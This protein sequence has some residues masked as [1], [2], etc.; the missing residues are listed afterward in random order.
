MKI[1]P[2]LLILVVF[3]T[4]CKQN[5]NAGSGAKNPVSTTGRQKGTV[6]PAN[7]NQDTLL[8]NKRSAVSFWLDSVQLEKRKNQYGANFETGADDYAYYSDVADSVLGTKHLPVINGDGY[9]YIKFV[10]SDGTIA[11]I[12]TD[13]LQAVYNLYLFNP[14]RAPYSADVTI[15]DDE[16]RKVYPK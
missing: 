2:I 13:T 6:K 8:I 14:D 4:N 5:G 11:L 10:R 9:K 15:M 1:I 3:L 16:Y 12:K 7:G